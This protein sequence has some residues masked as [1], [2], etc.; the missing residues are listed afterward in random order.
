[1]KDLP[2][3]SATTQETEYG[4]YTPDLFYTI[5]KRF[6]SNHNKRLDKYVSKK[7]GET[8]YDQITV[9]GSDDL[10]P[11][12]IDGQNSKYDPDCSCCFLHIPHTLNYHNEHIKN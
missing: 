9:T 10:S 7:T 3:I 2:I 4:F 12:H 8:S 5:D 6:C 11:V 1:M